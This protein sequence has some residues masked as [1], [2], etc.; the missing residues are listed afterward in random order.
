[1]VIQATPFADL[2]EM[3]WKSC[4]L[5]RV[6]QPWA[7]RPTSSS[8]AMVTEPPERR[9]RDLVDLAPSA[10]RQRARVAPACGGGR[11]RRPTR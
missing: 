4:A 7:A 6:N 11:I 2:V 5:F 10:R 3:S 1:M 9:H 8:V